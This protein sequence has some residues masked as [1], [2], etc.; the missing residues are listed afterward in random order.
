MWW[1]FW[2]SG[3]RRAIPFA[4]FLVLFVVVLLIVVNGYLLRA[5]AAFNSS[6]DP[7]TRRLLSLHALVLM[8]LLLVILLLFG[9]LTFRIG[10]FFFP[11]PTQTRTQTHYVDA[12]AEAG[13]R[14]NEQKEE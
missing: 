3:L 4:A 13:R 9:L 12:W 5:M 8:S 6:T 1:H 10:R 7:A 11:R 14:L 2:H